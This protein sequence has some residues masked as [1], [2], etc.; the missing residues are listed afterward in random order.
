[1]K[2]LELEPRSIPEHIL[3]SCRIFKL[4]CLQCI[5]HRILIQET[6]LILTW[7]GRYH[8]HKKMNLRA[9]ALL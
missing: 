6:N 3:Y 8:D 9:V 5:R 2:K 1:M 4:Q 7:Q